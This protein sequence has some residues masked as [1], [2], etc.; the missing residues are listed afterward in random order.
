MLSSQM[1][2]RLRQTFLHY[3]RLRLRLLPWS[4]P[5][6]SMTHSTV[7]RRRASRL[8]VT[9]LP[10]LLLRC[11]RS[12]LPRRILAMPA[13]ALLRLLRRLREQ[14]HWQ[15][16]STLVCNTTPSSRQ[17]RPSTP[18]CSSSTSTSSSMSCMVFG[19]FASLRPSQCLCTTRSPRKT[20]SSS[21]KTPSTFSSISAPR[22]WVACCCFD[23]VLRLP[24]VFSAMAPLAPSCSLLH[25][26]ALVTRVPERFAGRPTL[27][28]S[29]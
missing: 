23:V 21:S 13:C 17:S 3:R 9:P 10:L 29:A 14:R 7:G 12:L 1:L 28:T 26:E 27:D 4:F 18:S 6:T 22:A 15:L 25:R 20:S 8:T 2:S 19:K 11:V 5:W 16:Q 24:A